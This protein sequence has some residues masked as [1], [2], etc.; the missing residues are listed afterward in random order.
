MWTGWG[1]GGG[2]VAGG[3]GVEEDRRLPGGGA[4]VATDFVEPADK[5]GHGDDRR[6]ADHDAHDGK[7][8]AHLRRAQR[9]HGGK[10]V[11]ARLRCGHHGHKSQRK[12]F[13]FEILNLK[14]KTFLFSSLRRS[15][16]F[17]SQSMTGF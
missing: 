16:K 14:F 12:D 6:H 2:G 9:L 7:K 4:L 13:K 1:R 15:R 8:R 17:T 10:K 5:G 11:L 3:E